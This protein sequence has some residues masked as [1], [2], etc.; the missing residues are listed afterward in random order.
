M[1]IHKS[2]GLTFDKVMIDAAFSFSS[3][4]VYVA[5]SRCTSLAGIVLLSRIDTNAILYDSRIKEGVN[6]LTFQGQIDKY[7]QDSR[8]KYG[9]QLMAEM[10]DCSELL[11]FSNFMHAEIR[12][13]VDKFS[14]DS[15]P[16]AEALRTSF[17]NQ[18]I[19]VGQIFT[20]SQEVE[21]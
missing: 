8:Q 14:K 2:Q 20:K 5:L 13:V 7:L 3:G 19:I 4:Q 9:Y 17:T 12:K 21:R 6:K 10:L 16:E 18:Q 11:K 15:L 1:T